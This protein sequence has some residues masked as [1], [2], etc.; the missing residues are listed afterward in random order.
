MCVVVNG[1]SW[2]G[3]LWGCFFS[4]S[5]RGECVA[6]A[7]VPAYGVSCEGVTR[8]VFPGRVSLG[9]CLFGVC[10]WCVFLV[11]GVSGEGVHG[12]VSF[13]RVFPG[14]VLVFWGVFLRGCPW[15]G[16]FLVGCFL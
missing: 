11:G 5:V 6:R 14:R 7:C 10:S 4:T 16:C 2:D 8:R 15:G 3:V 13:V 12:G 9:V 1:V